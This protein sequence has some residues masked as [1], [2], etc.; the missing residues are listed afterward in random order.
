MF[1]STKRLIFTLIMGAVVLNSC[2]KEIT[3]DLDDLQT[4]DD[5]QDWIFPFINSDIQLE[6]LDS[7]NLKVYPDGTVYYTSLVDSVAIIE[8]DSIFKLSPT[9]QL[10]VENFLFEG[11]NTAAYTTT[12]LTSLQSILSNDGTVWSILAPLNNTTDIVPA[13]ASTNLGI[14]FFPAITEINNVT[15]DA[16]LLDV[17]VTNTATFPLSNITLKITNSNGDD[18]GTVFYPNVGAGETVTQQ[19]GMAGKTILSTIRYEILTFESPGSSNPVNINFST[20]FAVEVASTENMSVNTGVAEFNDPIFEFDFFYELKNALG[21]PLDEEITQVRIK[22]GT[23]QYLIS[24]N[25]STAI[26]LDGE[27]TGSNGPSGVVQISHDLPGLV[28]FTVNDQID[29]A[30]TTFDLTQDAFNPYNRIPIKFSPSHIFPAPNTFNKT[31]NISITFL[32]SDLEYEF[33]RGRFGEK[34][35]PLTQ[36]TVDWSDDDI[37]NHV[38]GDVEIENAKLNFYTYTNIGAD[39]NASL[40]G[41][42]ENNNSDI[43]NM[44]LNQELETSG[45]TPPQ[46]GNYILDVFSYDQTNSNADEIISFLPYSMTTAGQLFLNKNNPTREC[47][48]NDEAFMRV[49]VELETPLHLT[50]DTLFFI[51][52]VSYDNADF[53]DI[54]DLDTAKFIN[55]V[56]LHMNIEN[57]FPVSVGTTLMIIDSVDETTDSLLQTVNYNDVIDGAKVDANGET[58]ESTKY[59][60]IIEL[61]KEDRIALVNGDKILVKVNL[62][63]SKYNSTTPFVKLKSDDHFKLNLSV[64]V[65]NHI[66]VE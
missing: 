61:T 24:S 59:N 47:Y 58:I 39:Y 21:N 33:V 29:L 32:A 30:G 3:D 51:D 36:K 56:Y 10:S 1:S 42:V 27:I 57:D 17:K 16:G 55:S 26:K 49:D 15:Y 54:R 20:P 37:F 28:P 18:L 23:L 7:T 65:E 64:Q 38:S 12:K 66:P 34:T 19:I 63:T 50:A 40:L 41:Y 6:D 11:V 46:F 9:Q 2:V 52:T 62:L 48:I 14:Q 53:D 13:F 4:A 22:S 5:T 25:L 43:L 44:Q 35:I 31:D 45:P 8:P 60:N